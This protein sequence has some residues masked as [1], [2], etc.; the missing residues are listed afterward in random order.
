MGKKNESRVE[1]E[2]TMKGR[3][4]KRSKKKE[5]KKG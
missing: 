3:E 1:R 5:E 4:A 2:N